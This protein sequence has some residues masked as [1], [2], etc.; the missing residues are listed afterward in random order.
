VSAALDEGATQIPTRVLILGATSAIA[1]EV[2]RLYAGRGAHLCLVARNGEKLARLVADLPP[3]RVTAAVADFANLSN[4]DLV[5]SAALEALGGIDV[6]LVAHGDLGDQLE[7]ERSIAA[8][9]ATILANFTSVVAL[10]IPLANHM[11]SVGAGALG[12][13]TSVAGERGRPRN[14]T[15]GAA[16][17]ALNIYLQGLR[18]RLYGA[19]VK[20]TT[21]KLGPVATPMTRAHR[22][23]AVF[24]KPA[25]VARGIVA[26]LDAGVAEAY[27]P[28]F[29]AALM[30]IVRNTPERLFQALPF[31][32]GR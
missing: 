17:G 14:Y 27:V 10:L 3:E 23:T 16:K 6:A 22:K 1:S 5:V 29:W 31:L 15:Y 18:S 25:P 24:S 9:E 11:E 8:A 21:L 7:S 13:I 26:A 2:A 32:S 20:V 30:P 4:A 28:A 12:V 19:N